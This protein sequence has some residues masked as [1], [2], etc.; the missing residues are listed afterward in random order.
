MEQQD[1]LD[2]LNYYLNA[3]FEMYKSILFSSIV[4]KPNDFHL[5]ELINNLKKSEIEYLYNHF[6]LSDLSENIVKQREYA[7]LLWNRWRLFFD[8]EMPEENIT[9]EISDQKLE[10]IIR[11]YNLNQENS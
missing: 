3:K 7:I 9:I 2:K 6:H 1:D 8:K 11:V 4:R 10:I 5:S